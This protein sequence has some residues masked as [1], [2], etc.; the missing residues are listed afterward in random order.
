MVV[1]VCEQHLGAELDVVHGGETPLADPP[2][3]L[4][5][6]VRGEAAGLRAGR[7]RRRGRIDRVVP[8]PDGNTIAFAEPPDAAVTE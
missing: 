8:D 2:A 3:E 6:V 7:S 5:N 1:R 4:K